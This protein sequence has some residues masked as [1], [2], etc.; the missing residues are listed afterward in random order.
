MPL[1]HH[2]PVK[3]VYLA[4]EFL[5]TLF[6]RLPYWILTSLHPSWRPR[7]S[8]GIKYCICIY[9]LRKF[10]WIHLRVNGAVPAP[11]HLAVQA[12]GRKDVHGVWIPPA[13]SESI[14]GE[15]KSAAEKAGVESVRIPGYWYLG[16]EI[17]GACGKSEEGDSQEETVI[18]Y[19]HGGAF[20]TFSAH[21]SDPCMPSAARGL[22]E[23]TPVRR[24]LAL[25]YRLSSLNPQSN[26][27][28]AAIL[29]AIAGYLYLSKLYKNIIIAGDSAG[30]N[31]AL[32]LT[33]YIVSNPEIHLQKPM[34]L[35]LISPWT[36]L[37]L[38]HITEGSSALPIVRSDYADHLEPTV[39]GPGLSEY[40][41]SAYLG[42]QRGLEEEDPYISP[43]S[44]NIRDLKFDG[45][46][47][48]MIVAGSAEVLLDEMKTLRDM[49]A[50]DLGIERVRYLEVKD[51]VHNFVCWDFCGQQREEG[52]RG[53]GEWM[54]GQLGERRVAMSADEK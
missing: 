30:A 14:V 18:F 20:I 40:A 6:L 19:L 48:T 15:I 26:P 8:W 9:A 54:N 49:M 23:N 13:P 31:L 25:E 41:V 51:A 24:I 21:P 50:G 52:L 45:Y 53:I 22:L 42:T 44:R 10:Y 4:S 11:N 17:A 16:P 3:A 37:G 35:L 2:H 32:A 39:D 34:A 36:D 28:P 12:T 33:R 27:Y 1:L 43:A 47:Q 46:P 5:A 29:D 38:S 7:K